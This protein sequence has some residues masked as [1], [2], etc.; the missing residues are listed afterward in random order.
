MFFKIFIY[1]LS[2]LI[3]RI[4]YVS[5]SYKPILLTQFKLL[6]SMR[7]VN[8]LLITAVVILSWGCNK[9]VDLDA[10]KFGIFSV[11]ENGTSVIAEGT[12]GSQTLDHF[13]TLLENYPDIDLI[14][15]TDMPGSNDDAT[16]VLLGRAVYNQ[17]LSIHIEDNGEIASGAVDLF[18]AG[19]ERTKGANTKIGV[20]S[21]GDGNSE[22]TDFPEDSSEHDLYI[23]YYKDIGLSDEDARTFYFFTI[24]A[25]PAADI[26]WMTEEEIETYNVLTQ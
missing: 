23:N 22:A 11:E 17:A 26:H 16:N 12:I 10:R 4:D 24:N 8:V 20:H 19:R 14:K 18:L 3:K 25:A 9:D 15:M 2:F 7:I 21:W 5:F 6:T 13:N 1:I